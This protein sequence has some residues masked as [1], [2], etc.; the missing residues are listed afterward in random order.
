M[1][2]A[3]DR[4]EKKN[5]V[6]IRWSRLVWFYAAGIVFM[7]V[8]VANHLTGTLIAAA[9]MGWAVAHILDTHRVKREIGDAK[10]EN[11]LAVKGRR[12][13]I[14]EPLTYEISKTAADSSAA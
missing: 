10:K 4:I 3:Y 7:A 14:R 12:F 6:T 5:S 9:A 1:G 11:R 13:S 2:L 8:A